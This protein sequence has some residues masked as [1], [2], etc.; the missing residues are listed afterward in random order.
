MDVSPASQR[1]I[2]CLTHLTRFG[3]AETQ[4]RAG[5]IWSL[6][7]K[8]VVHV[9]VQLS[10]LTLNLNKLR[11][12]QDFPFSER[13]LRELWFSH[14][15]LLLNMQLTT[16]TP[17]S[18]GRDV[19]LMVSGCSFSGGCLLWKEFTLEMYMLLKARYSLVLFF[20]HHVSPGLCSDLC[21]VSCSVANNSWWYILKVRCLLTSAL[22]LYRCPCRNL[23]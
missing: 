18:W 22:V 21:I 13:L 11:A 2:A 12:H 7:Q 23:L 16:P 8:H 1:L 6:P 14:Q 3:R 15:E 19:H 4:A 20:L 10:L 5:H 17:P 9:T